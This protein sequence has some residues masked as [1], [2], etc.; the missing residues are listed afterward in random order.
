MNIEAKGYNGR[1]TFDGSAITIHRES[2]TAKHYQGKG[3]KVI[4]LSAISAIHLQPPGRQGFGVWQVSLPGETPTQVKHGFMSSTKL[5]RDENVVLLQPKHMDDFRALTDA[6]N[7]AK[8]APVPPHAVT[9]GSSPH[10]AAIAQLRTLGA[11]HWD[12]RLSDEAF[13]AEVHKI[14]QSL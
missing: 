4:P 7:R 6:I 3:A 14:L 9:Q 11:L 10:D 2:L 5:A 8:A 1:V 12:K 13:I